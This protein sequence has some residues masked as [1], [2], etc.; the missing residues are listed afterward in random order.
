MPGPP[1]RDSITVAGQSTRIPVRSLHMSKPILVGLAPERDDRAPLTLGAA[2]ARVTGAPLIVL[3]AYLHDPI[4]SAISGGTVDEDLR[5]EALSKLEALTEGADADLLVSGGPSPARVLHDTAQRLGAAMIVVGSTG[6]GPL[7]RV[8]PGTTAERLLHGA[9]CPVVVAPSDL[10]AD[11][12]PRHIG[13]GFL[14]IDEGH[15]ALRAAAVLAR[16]AGGTLRATTAVEPRAWSASAVMAP[17]D[18]D[19]ALQA[20]RENAKREL[21]E[22]LELLQPGI[23]SSSDVVIGHAAD[24]LI[25]SSRHVD[26][27]VCG[28]RGYGPLRSVLLG[29]ATHR[30][31][32]HAHCPVLIVPRHTDEALDDLATY[33]EATTR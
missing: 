28:S 33:Q 3:A 18:A 20:S 29:G 31:L 16:A 11:W 25:D 27:L 7:G 9:P 30:L 10:P 8:T 21:D 4:T 23:R 6:R 1:V 24:A 13:V 14:D 22:A 17:Y 5:G 19:G 15:A 12:E 32:R 26:L 2:L